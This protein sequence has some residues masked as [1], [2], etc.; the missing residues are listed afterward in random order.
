MAATMNERIEILDR[1]SRNIDAI[2]LRIID[3]S[4]D[5]HALTLALKA[6]IID[7]RHSFDAAQRLQEEIK[8][9]EILQVPDMQEP[10]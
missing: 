2:S 7:T 1:W 6:E 5:L 10:N 3:I 4:R 8:K 9:D